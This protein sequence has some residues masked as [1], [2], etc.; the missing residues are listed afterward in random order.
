MKN[1]IFAFK[2]DLPKYK[3]IY[4]Q[5]K[6][7]IEQGKLN[8]NEQLPSIRELA[9]SLQVSRNTTLMAYD[10]LVAE[11]Y[12]RGEGRKGYFINELETLPF[13]VTL[14]SS[15]KKP[16]EPSNPILIDFRPGAVDQKQFPLK[17][18]RRL[19][20]QALTL[21]ESFQ[22]GEP[23]GELCLREQIATYLLQS[24]GVRTEADSI[25]IGSSTQQ[26]LINLGHILKSDFSSVIVEDPGYD[27]A[28]EAFQFHRFSFEAI[29]VQETGADL[30][31]LERMKSRLIYVTPSHHSPY[32]VSMSIQQR[33]TLV[34]WVNKIEGYI[35]EDDYDSEFR[36]TQQPFPALASID[37]ARVIYLGNFSKSFLPGI[38]LSYMVLPQPLLNVYKKQFLYFESTTS[39]LS[40][41]TMAKFMESGEWSRHIKRMRL[42]Y[43]QKMHYIVSELKKQ[44]KDN[45]TIIGEQS[46][47]YLLVKVHL[48]CSEEQLIQQASFYG[49]KVY[50]TSIYFV[51]KNTDNPIIKLGFTNLTFEDIQSGVTLLKNAWLEKSSCNY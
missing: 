2:D 7:L 17:T 25:I 18:W 45:I 16:S 39:I 1:I 30:S 35:I 31:Q 49:V 8:A 44:F 34:Q 26:M 4:E 14:S 21:P 38:R 10:Q 12:I 40:Q 48:D 9:H 19:Y 20:N 37:S 43:K 41:F 27:G 50:P 46:G 29:P 24:R 22:Y 47:L 42:V 6:L 13:Q 28:R 32:G 11:G 15:N 5:F 23:F 36:Y 51:H 33:H 3:Q